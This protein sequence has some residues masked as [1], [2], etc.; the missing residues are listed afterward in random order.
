MV[1]WHQ[2]PEEDPPRPPLRPC[3]TISW[4]PP[5]DCKIQKGKKSQI[6]RSHHSQLQA[7]QTGENNRP[8][9]GRIGQGNAPGTSTKKGDRNGKK[10]T[11]CKPTTQC[12]PGG[13][14]RKTTSWARPFHAKFETRG[15][16]WSPW[17]WPSSPLFPANPRGHGRCRS[18]R[19]A[20]FAHRVTPRKPKRN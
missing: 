1:P 6:G 13:T 17:F 20:H 2:W 18:A 15:A 19:A 5:S 11:G 7:F 16:S 14:F 9:L 3:L 12:S 10:S 8:G 4:A